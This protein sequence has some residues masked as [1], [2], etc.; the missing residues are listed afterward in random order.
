M[1]HKFISGLA[2]IGLA[3]ILASHTSALAQASAGSLNGTITYATNGNPLHNVV[4]TITQLRRTAETDEQGKYS[5]DNLP[6]GTYTVLA[7]NEGFP[8]VAQK[9][10]VTAGGATTLDFSM[11][12]TGVR[13]QVTVTATGSEQATFDAVESV[14]TVASTQILEQATSS[15]GEALEKQTGVAKRSFGPGSSRP[16]VRGFDGDRVLVLEDGVRTGSVGSQSGDHGE[17][18]DV[19]SVE[20]LEVVRGP[21]TLLY[22]SNAIGGVVNA[23]SGRDETKHQGARGYFSTFGGSNNNTAGVSGSLEYGRGPWLVWGNGTGQR[24]GNFN[25]PLGRVENSQFRNGNGGGGV[26]YYAG[27]GFFNAGYNYDNRRYGIP[28]SEDEQPVLALRRHNLRFNGGLRDLDSFITGAKFAVNYTN[29]HHDELDEGAIATSFDN[30]TTSYRATFDQKRTGR[31]AGTFGAEGYHRN[32]SSVG[33]EALIPGKVTVNSF[34]AFTL[35]EY[36][37]ERAKLQFGGRIEN[38]RY[39][40]TDA[41]RPNRSFT[42]FSGGAGARFG[43][44][45]DGAFVVNYTHAE[46]APALEELYNDGPHPGNLTFEIGDPTLK[47]E[48]SNGLEFSLRHSAARVRLEGNLFYYRLSNF[49]FLAPTGD[50]EDGLPVANYI[51]ADSRYLG[52]EANLEI[53]ARNNLW[54]NAGLDYVNA[55]LRNSRTPLPRIPPFRARLGLDYRYQGLS[56]RPEVA[57]SDKQD[58][59]FTNETPTAGYGIFNLTTSYTLARP[60]YAHIF[61]ANFF[62]LSDKLYRN[63][64]SFVKET[65]PEIGRGVRFSYTVR[66][67]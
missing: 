53:Q 47:R 21:A 28:G 16:V 39:R 35:Q 60:H 30:K 29:Y 55:E 59:V 27:Q 23:V 13:E 40:P 57:F 1:F 34:S 66:F 52:A 50:E 38:N 61:S 19:L 25:T 15:L 20:R 64:L 43:L 12:I 63:H 31:W 10:T 46:R 42:G 33:A 62:N 17:P 37:G 26:G 3:L 5:F 32:Y 45:K 48:K 51:Q 6:A 8:D 49:I 36:G 11:Q 7:H 22:G 65:V 56:I 14:S 44:W 58:R 4:V 67:F 18:L 41:S 9:I 54:F 24:T 2:V